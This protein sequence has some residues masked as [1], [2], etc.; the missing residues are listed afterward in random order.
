MGGGGGGW[1]TAVPLA[2]GHRQLHRRLART[3]SD[4]AM[5]RASLGFALLLA[6]GGGEQLPD[7]EA[8]AGA[9]DGKLCMDARLSSK[10]LRARGIA[11]DSPRDGVLVEPL[12]GG[13]GARPRMLST[14]WGPWPP[15]SRPR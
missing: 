3:R 5:R 2:F 14:A 8:C 13:Y 12:P 9:P 6:L 11:P 15:T 4:V 7:D 1:A 10:Q